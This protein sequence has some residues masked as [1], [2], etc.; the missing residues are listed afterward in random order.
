[1]A[2]GGLLYGVGVAKE[3]GFDL[4]WL[5]AEGGRDAVCIDWMILEVL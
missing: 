5:W 1:M 3:G 4:V 2:L